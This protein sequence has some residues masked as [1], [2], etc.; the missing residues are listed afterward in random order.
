MKAAVLAFGR[1]GTFWCATA[2]SEAGRL[3]AHHERVG[4]GGDLSRA[5]GGVEVNSFLRHRVDEVCN[6]FPGATL[7]RLVRDGRDVVRSAMTRNVGTEFE[8]WCERWARD[9]DR[10]SGLPTWRLE[11]LTSDYDVFG[12]FVDFLGGHPLFAPW[13]RLRAR[14]LNAS[15]RHTFPAWEDWTPERTETFWRICGETMHEAGYTR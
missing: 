7:V 3:D 2:L 8:G 1:S 6:T 14:R 13:D 12:V 11:D 4:K 9:N 10:I 5:D 15:P